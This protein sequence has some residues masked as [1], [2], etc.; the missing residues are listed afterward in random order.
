MPYMHAVMPSVRFSTAESGST[1]DLTVPNLTLRHHCAH[2]APLLPLNTH[3]K[4]VLDCSDALYAH[5]DAQCQ[6]L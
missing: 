2:K 5:S 4:L 1:A 3:L 6:I